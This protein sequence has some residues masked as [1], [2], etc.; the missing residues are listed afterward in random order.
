MWAPKPVNTDGEAS[1]PGPSSS[2]EK[3]PTDRDT[4]TDSDAPPPLVDDV[5]SPDELVPDNVRSD[6]ADDSERQSDDDI[7]NEGVQDKINWFNQAAAAIHQQMLRDQPRHPATARV[8]ATAINVIDLDTDANDADTEPSA[9]PVYR[10]RAP[11][12]QHNK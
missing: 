11:K 1:N 12:T 2:D 10:R 4:D 6:I 5:S 3:M 7:G 8:A 9:R